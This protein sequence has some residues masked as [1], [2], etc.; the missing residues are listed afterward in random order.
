MP[1]VLE[2]RNLSRAEA[3]VFARATKE[4]LPEANVQI[5]PET[6]GEWTVR[7]ELPDAADAALTVPIGTIVGAAA[8]AVTATA[9]KSGGAGNVGA[10]AL[11]MVVGTAAGI[12][13]DAL[14]GELAATGAKPRR[15]TFV[16]AA[17]PLT[18][19]DFE[20][21]ANDLGC[22]IAAIKAV[23]QVE[24]AGKGFLSDGRPKILFE[25]HVFSDLTGHQHDETHPGVSS[26]KWD[27]LLYKGGEAEYERLAEA[28]GLDRQ[29]A[30]KSASWGRYQIV[31]RNHA[32]AGFQNV[33]EFVDAMCATER[34]HMR[35]FVEFIKRY[36]VMHNALQ[37]KNW[38]EFA[39]RYNGPAY[40]KHDYHGKMK[41]AYE[42]HSV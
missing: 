11:A 7:F 1:D 24:S 17:T 21:A 8:G 34:E 35:A 37:A 39:R 6:D 14:A 22:E 23:D 9:A 5:I 19:E 3:E 31:G 29:A 42:K 28:I 4:E 41:A 32:A 38:E 33:E 20:E 27:R 16:G 36:R 18:D 25:A 26:R 12:A 30:L 15:N 13:S 40:A 2:H 10:S